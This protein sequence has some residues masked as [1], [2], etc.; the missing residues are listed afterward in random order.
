M[1]TPSTECYCG[2]SQLD[3]LKLILESDSAI[4]DRLSQVIQS[5]SEITCCAEAGSQFITNGSDLVTV[6]FPVPFASPPVVVVSVSKPNAASVLIDSNV[7][8]TDVTA[9]GFTASLGAA[10]VGV[11]YKLNWIAQLPT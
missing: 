7:N 5:V 8:R 10:P 2:M 6:V 1:A 9:T 4:F 3:I 11:D